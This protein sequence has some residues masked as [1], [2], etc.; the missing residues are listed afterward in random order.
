MHQGPLKNDPFE[1]DPYRNDVDVVD[2]VVIVFNNKMMK[3][4]SELMII[5]YAVFHV[6]VYIQ[7]NTALRNQTGT[8]FCGDVVLD[9][10]NMVFSLVDSI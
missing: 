1:K 7:Q 3:K 9:S 5:L 4:S 10:F 2:V 6:I 8:V